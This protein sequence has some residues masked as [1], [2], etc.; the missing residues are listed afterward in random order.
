MN[1]GTGITAGLAQR[2]YTGWHF[3]PF[4][5]EIS[6][7]FA[8][9]LIDKGLTIVIVFFILNVLPQKL[10]LHFLAN[11]YFDYRQLVK[12]R[13]KV[14]M[15][16]LSFNI[17]VLLLISVFIV[18]ALS[19]SVSASTYNKTTTEQYIA[20]DTSLVNMVVEAVDGD[21][22]ND[23][24]VEGE[25]TDS[26]QNT[27]NELYTIWQSF[28]NVEYVYVY[29]IR[30]D[31]CH[32]IFD[33][34][35]PDT[36]AGKLG[37]IVEFDQAFEPYLDTLLA[38]GEIEPVIDHGQFGWLLT[39]YKPIYDSNGKCVAYAAADIDMNDVMA[40]RYAYIV[41]I[42]SL[43]LAIAI[44]LIACISFYAQ[45]RLIMPINAMAD[46]SNRFAYTSD[47]ERDQ[48][49][50]QIIK[51]DIHTGD[52][53]ENLYKAM[54]KTTVD[55][56]NYIEQIQNN[57]ESIKIQTA[58]ISK[59][60]DNIIVSFAD[61][62]ENRDSNTGGHIR[63]TATY[64]N[65]IA[66]ELIKEGCYSDVLTPEYLENIVKS[67]PLHDIGKI[68]IPDSILDKPNSLSME[69]IT[70]MRS[71]T[72]A[73]VEIIQQALIGIENS[74][75]LNT[76]MEMAQSHHERWDGKGYPKG[77][78]GNQ[79]PLSARI[80][81]VADVLDALL[82]KRSYK[83]TMS[84]DEA[85]AIIAKESGTQFDPLCVAALVKAKE[86]IREVHLQEDKK[87]T[88]KMA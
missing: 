64:V 28:E 82:S 84:F 56:G 74:S 22:V 55:V 67:A 35:T 30:E 14:R 31:G 29:Q 75:Y 24:F 41:K 11:N 36:P 5:S 33:V 49:A 7:D 60:Q 13:R 1:F 8:I 10:R 70:V 77:L 45:Y 69:E 58:T 59:M 57:I 37:E 85:V 25:E 53:L 73:G 80:M 4:W 76:A 23:Y 79:I 50:A 15:V 21:K 44:A 52:E 27:K 6:A 19:I 66:Q 17:S 46:V 68:K 86:K 40:D 20:L 18:G 71:H 51:L 83:E 34:E 47:E 88:K 54:V 78:K 63:R 12:A 87:E 62:V 26:Y 48:N 2:I 39:V 65:S 9:D 32:V 81:A 3:S 16:P 61:M 72:T 42:S 43:A 38:G